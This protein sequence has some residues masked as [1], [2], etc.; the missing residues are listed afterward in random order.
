GHR[1]QPRPDRALPN[2]GPP[3]P[4]ESTSLAPRR[5]SD[6]PQRVRLHR[7]TPWPPVVPRRPA[8]PAAWR[9]RRQPDSARS[10]SRTGGDTDD[11]VKRLLRENRRPYN[12]G[13]DRRGERS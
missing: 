1:P 2:L 12:V 3:T 8:G 4:R 13:D 7:P 6:P 11:E 9:G 5:S 10:R